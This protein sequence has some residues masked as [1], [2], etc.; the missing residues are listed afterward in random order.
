MIDLKLDVNLDINFTPDG[1]LE[2]WDEIGT[3]ILVALFSNKD[4]LWAD[5]DG[6]YLYLLEQSRLTNQVLLDIETYAR[7][8]LQYLIDGGQ[9]NR[10]DVNVDVDIHGHVHLLFKIVK[11]D[12]TIIDQYYK[13]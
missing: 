8:A 6:S 11:L 10:V 2:H 13:L 5:K 12:G 9:C 7:N 3:S 1:D 4:K